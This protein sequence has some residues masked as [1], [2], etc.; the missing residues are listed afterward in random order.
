[1]SRKVDVRQIAIDAIILSPL[2]NGR[3]KIDT[4]DLI[5]NYSD[6]V[7]VTAVDLAPNP[8]GAPY[9]VI[10]FKEDEKLYYCGGI[11]LTKIVNRLLEAFDGNFDEL[12]A[13]LAKE[14]LGIKLM[15]KK[16]SDGKNNLTVVDIVD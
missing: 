4:S 15:E 7:H 14:P 5:K 1:M 6:G 13:E 2:M 8:N 9:S 12:N 3:T 16:T 10:Q 11:I